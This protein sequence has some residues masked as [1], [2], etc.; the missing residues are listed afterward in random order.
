MRC[1]PFLAGKA[2]DGLVGTES[3]PAAVSRGG[4]FLI[5][6]KIGVNET[7]SDSVRTKCIKKPLDAISINIIIHG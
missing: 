4:R 5:L 7:C 2:A 6:I 1:D 3:A